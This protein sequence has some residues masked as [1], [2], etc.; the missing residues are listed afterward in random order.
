MDMLLASVSEIWGNSMARLVTHPK[1]R[2]YRA[3]TDMTCKKKKKKFYRYCT[4]S[5][6]CMDTVVDPAYRKHHFL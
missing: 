2:Y 6:Y 1:H 3:D 5:Q 4:V